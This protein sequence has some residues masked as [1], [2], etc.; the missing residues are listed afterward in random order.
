MQDYG[1]LRE[2]FLR[3]RKCL[4]A[5]KRLLLVNWLRALF[6]WND[7]FLLETLLMLAGRNTN[8]LTALIFIFL[9][10]A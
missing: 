5:K 6:S 8:H 9:S 2:F 4:D 7:P 3:E 1:S 10:F